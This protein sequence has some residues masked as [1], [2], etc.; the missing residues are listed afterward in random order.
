MTTNQHTAERVI[1]AIRVSHP[2]SHPV[3]ACR[4]GNIQMV[5]VGWSCPLCDRD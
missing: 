4:M 1:R 2:F 3:D 5:G